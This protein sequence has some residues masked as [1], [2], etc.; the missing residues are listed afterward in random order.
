MQTAYDSP[1][2]R[3]TS[4]S[5]TSFYCRRPADGISRDGARRRP[6]QRYRGHLR[7]RCD[8]PL[9]GDVLV[10]ARCGAGFRCRCD[11]GAP[12]EGRRTRR[13]TDRYAR[14]S[15][16]V[17]WRGEEANLGAT[18]CIDA[19]GFQ[20]RDPLDFAVEEPSTV[21]DD[22]A[23]TIAVD[24]R[25]AIIGVFLD[26][27][28]RA[29]SEPAKKGVNIGMG[30]DDDKRYNDHLR[31]LIVGGRIKPSKIVSHRLP[32]RDAPDAFAKFDARADGYLKIV[33]EPKS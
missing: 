31:D 4:G 10:R 12:G 24:G 26:N 2:N 6:L 1:A 18:V 27:D 3:A 21:I 33:L 29:P 25:L 23:R 15:Q 32:L 8:W 13:R 11:S 22:L 7:R 5:T 17:A 14:R 30:R 28:P 20:A 16:G 9:I 19:I